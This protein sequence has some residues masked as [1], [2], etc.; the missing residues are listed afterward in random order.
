MIVYLV[1]L[2]MIVSCA[3]MFGYGVFSPDLI[4]VVSFIVMIAAVVFV[5]VSFVWKGL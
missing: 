2:A 5:V 1:A 4:D 3:V